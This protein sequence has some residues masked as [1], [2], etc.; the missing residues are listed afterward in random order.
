M[1]MKPLMSKS[2]DIR[3]RRFE[4]LRP[5]L[6]TWFMILENYIT[7]VPKDLPFWYRERPQIG[8]LA[9]AAWQSGYAA[10]EEWGMVKGSQKDKHRGRNDLWIGYP[11]GQEWF[12]EAKHDWCDVSKG[13]TNCSDPLEKTLKSARTSAKQ[14]NVTGKQC[15]CEKVA[16]AFVT[17]FWNK[18]L[19]KPNFRKKMQR[20][21]LEACDE[22]K[23]GVIA[24]AS[25]SAP[26]KYK[27]GKNGEVFFG[28]ALL[29]TTLEQ[30]ATSNEHPRH[31]R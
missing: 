23:A 27:P 15:L 18:K 6:E 16:A 24:L 8:F 10:L 29:L 14:V 22:A 3:D 17:P 26:E 12:I 4:P 5:I 28:M 25:I 13:K 21:W 7:R 19:A 31:H 11:G 30:T 9:A 2:L 20:D 1:K